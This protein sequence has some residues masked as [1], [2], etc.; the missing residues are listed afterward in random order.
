MKSLT[1]LF[2]SI[3]RPR[4]L[5]CAALVAAS[6]TTAQAAPVFF[7]AAGTG[8]PGTLVSV[9]DELPGNAL[10]VGAWPLIQNLHVGQT[11]AAFTLYYQAN[12]RLIDANGN[13]IDTGPNVITA[14]A[15]F[16][17]TA[18]L[19]SANTVVFNNAANQTGSYF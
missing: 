1:Q 13:T 3:F 19:V 11:S 5:L 16:Q 9:F 17:E 6:S 14:V 8:G 12:V 15:K 2:R 7:N 18:T 4:A 10:A